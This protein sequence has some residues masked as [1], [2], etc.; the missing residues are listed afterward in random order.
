MNKSPKAERRSDRNRYWKRRGTLMAAAAAGL[1]GLTSSAQ[2]TVLTFEFF[3]D[4][5]KTTTPAN[6]LKMIQSYGDNVT[7]F[8]PAAAATEG[9]YVRYGSGG[10]ATPNVA[11][12]YRYH[13]VNVPTD[14]ALT[15]VVIYDT[16]FGDLQ[17]VIYNAQ[18]Q[19]WALEIR[20]IPQAGYKVTLESFDLAGYLTDRV[21]PT[22]AATQD[23]TTVSA[24]DLWG[25]LN[26]F[27]IP[28]GATHNHY[29]PGVTVESGHWLSLYFGP[30]V[31]GVRGIDNVRF[32]QS[33]LPEPAS[34]AFLTLGGAAMLRRRAR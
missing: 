21:V 26:N 4:A 34:L 29:T 14:N 1:I 5:A 19:P 6:A 24:V 3:T 13:N 27:T 9:H 28:G 30:D 20:L 7:D 33:P 31:G 25:P 23:L 10:G 15:G 18:P 22:M 2:A 12:E 11:V 16:G 8:D 32:S 17:N